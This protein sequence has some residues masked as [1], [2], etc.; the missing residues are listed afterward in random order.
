MKSKLLLALGLLILGVRAETDIVV[1][2]GT[3]AGV[4]AAVQAKKMGRSV[5]LIEPGRHLGG[6]TS[7]GLGA[8][9]AGNH[10][11]IGGLSREFY[12]RIKKHYD[13]DCAWKW[14][15]KKTTKQDA[16][17]HFEPHVAEQIFRDMLREAGV[18]VVFGERLDLKN[19]VKK[20]GARIT[21]IVMESGKTFS[22]QMF[23]DATYEG[24]VLAK[25]GVSYTVGRE[26]NAQYGETLNGV[27]V[28]RAKSHQFMRPVDPY[29]K[30]GDP[31]SRLL[32]GVQ[33]GGPG[34]D[35][36]ADKCVQAYNFRMC[37]TDA[38]EN[39][40]P[41]PKPEGYDPL[42]YELLLRYLIPEWNDALAG[43]ARMPNR[44]TDTNNRGGFSTDNI[45]MNYD[46]P[47]GD[48]ATRE[49]IIKEHETYQ[50]GL[51]WF[52]SNDPRVP[53]TVRARMEKWGLAKDEFTD[54]G[55][56]PHQIYVREARRM[57]GG[58]V[59][60]EQD[61]RRTRVT[62]ESVGM[63]SYTMDSH[64]CQ[65]YVD[66][67]GHVRT[68]GDVQVKAGG[69]YMISYHSLVPKAGECSNLIVPVCVSASH[70]AYGSIRMEPVF[71]ILGQSAATAACLALEDRVPVQNVAYEKLRVRL[72]ADG[73]VLDW[74]RGKATLPTK[75]LQKNRR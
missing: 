2:G 69:P 8:T 65:R 29:R 63:G 44:K 56:W 7:G 6:L 73:Q 39:R 3:S 33:A 59:H 68:E 1:Y 22:G 23:I 31:T 20:D 30:P 9:D 50:K 58:Y 13:Q 37:L 36:T 5:V 26:A 19:G 4:A 62:P 43:S 67:S 57:V 61:C 41:F 70:I 52:V 27:Q 35:G 42:R 66:A 12:Q 32:P 34:E 16:L 60:T 64:N 53:A 48:Y 24:D 72:L 51:M 28:A 71:M 55:N 74:Q 18:E 40:A 14:E 10:A 46:Y 21:A 49:R 17:W 38:P 11:V 75:S 54:N 47:E 15:A 45:G 25:A